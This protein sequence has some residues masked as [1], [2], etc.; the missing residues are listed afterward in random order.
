M[1]IIEVESELIRNNFVRT[2]TPTSL[3]IV[4]H[5]VPGSGK[6]SIIKRLIA[7]NKFQAF[8]LGAP[9]G[10][11]LEHAGV[12]TFGTDIAKPATATTLILDEYQLGDAN[13]VS[14][15]SV[16]FGDPFQ[17]TFRLPA[18]YTNATSFRV[19]RPVCDWLSRCSFSIRGTKPGKLTSQPPFVKGRHGSPVQGQAIH[20]GEISKALLHSH[21]ICSRHPR[22]LRG[23]EFNTVT[24]V[25]HSSEKLDRA[26][27]Y[28]AATRA[29][30]HLIVISD[31][32]DEFHT[33][34]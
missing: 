10:Q 1:K 3:P 29:L 14:N 20:L 33:A 22:E 5:G 21:G 31:E 4:I 24:L 15:F 13:V 6:S 7:S 32:F 27:F 19:P 2:N 11:N 12:P 34:T 8:T 16:L 23:L 17:G 18:H 26:D 28:V 9:Y 30:E 25:Y